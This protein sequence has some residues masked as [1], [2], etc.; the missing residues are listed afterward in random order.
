MCVCTAIFCMQKCMHKYFV[1]AFK[2]YMCIDVS[3]YIHTIYITVI[4]TCYKEY[5]VLLSPF[6]A[7]KRTLSVL[8]AFQISDELGVL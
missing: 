7:V 8:F 5:C 1:F 2:Y 4:H 3:F 6:T